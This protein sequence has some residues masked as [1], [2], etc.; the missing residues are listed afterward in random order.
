M[1]S[2][3]IAVCFFHALKYV[4]FVSSSETEEQQQAGLLLAPPNTETQSVAQQPI[5]EC[6][7]ESVV[8][9]STHI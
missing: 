8:F 5:R 1:K 6:N 4:P 3:W 2:N 7:A 9:Q